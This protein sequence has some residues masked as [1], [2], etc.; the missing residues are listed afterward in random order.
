[1]DRLPSSDTSS[2]LSPRGETSDSTEQSAAHSWRHSNLSLTTHYKGESSWWRS[3]AADFSG[4][5]CCLTASRRRSQRLVK[6]T[7]SAILQTHEITKWCMYYR[8]L[9]CALWAA[10]VRE[11]LSRA[12][13]ERNDQAPGTGP[14]FLLAV[15]D[16]AR[17]QRSEV[18]VSRGQWMAKFTAYPWWPWSSCRAK[19]SH[20][21]R[22]RRRA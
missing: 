20:G 11:P 6:P 5:R 1:M 16:S 15:D 7:T 22:G 10:R 17:R 9:L 8:S 4:S 12:F 2:L 14:S 3:P 21:R 13:R 18:S 19:G